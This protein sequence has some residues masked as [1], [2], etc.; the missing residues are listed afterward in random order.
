MVH[1]KHPSYKDK[2]KEVLSKTDYSMIIARDVLQMCT[3][4][5]TVQVIFLSISIDFLLLLVLPNLLLHQSHVDQ[6]AANLRGEKKVVNKLIHNKR[7]NQLTFTGP[8]LTILL[9]RETLSKTT[10]P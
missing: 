1:S 2:A 7:P 6:M 9:A 10:W 3:D 4:F 5:V 8:S